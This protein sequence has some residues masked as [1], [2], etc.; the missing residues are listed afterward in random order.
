MLLS[1][2]Q[3]MS[4]R[5]GMARSFV[6]KLFRAIY[7]GLVGAL[8]GIMRNLASVL[9]TQKT[10]LAHSKAHKRRNFITDMLLC[11]GGPVYTMLALYIVQPYRYQIQTVMGCITLYDRSWPSVALVLMWPAIFSIVVIYYSG[12]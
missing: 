12:T 5:G 8:I 1:G 4:K 2:Q 7:L 11:F 9:D 10:V 6:T 3:M